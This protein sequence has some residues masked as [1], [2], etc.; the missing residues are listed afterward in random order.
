LLIPLCV[1]NKGRRITPQFFN[2]EKEK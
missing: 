2:A 1:T